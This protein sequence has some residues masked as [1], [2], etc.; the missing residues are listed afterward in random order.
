MDAIIHIDI[1]LIL[2]LVHIWITESEKHLI[3]GSLHLTIADAA[4]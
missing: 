3:S 1:I 2:M 4:N